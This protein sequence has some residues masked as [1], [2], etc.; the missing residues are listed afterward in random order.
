VL[1]K[2]GRQFLT[3][4][5]II[6]FGSIPLLA[7]LIIVIWIMHELS[8]VFMP[9]LLAFVL[10]YI[11][12]P[13]IN[14][15]VSKKISRSHAIL[16]VY[17]VFTLLF[18]IVFIT[19]IP[20]IYKE[21][22]RQ[23][24]NIPAMVTELNEKL[25]DE[26]SWI[27]EGM[28]HMGMTKEKQQEIVTNLT[29]NF[30]ENIQ[31]IFNGIGMFIKDALLPGIGSILGYLVTIILIPIYMYFF[32]LGMTGMYNKVFEYVPALHRKKTRVVLG[33]IHASV[34]AFFRGRVLICSIIGTCTA[35]GFSFCDM[36]F[37]VLLGLV[38]GLASMIPFM[39]TLAFVPTLLVTWAYPDSSGWTMLYVTLIFVIFQVSDFVLTPL[40]MKRGLGLHPVTLLIA[41]FSGYSLLGF[42]GML[43]AIPITS[44]LKILGTEVF[45]PKFRRISEIRFTTNDD[46]C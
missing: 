30:G 15:L 43:L 9:V 1:T 36:P 35:I 17:I 2:K 12:N 22:A 46:G 33:K 13:L 18:A 31:T 27:N 16:Y 34:S 39:S 11:L 24:E 29:K 8:H 10:A 23:T 44:S 4:T 3:D 42:F 26:D 38:I 25:Q 32:L 14:W 28:R 19:V 20:R 45:L 7:G 5:I 37:P 41:L 40:I 21:I 6:V